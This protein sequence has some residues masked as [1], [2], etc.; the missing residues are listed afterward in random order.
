[1]A[2]LLKTQQDSRFQGAEK[3]TTWLFSFIKNLFQVP[4]PR[5]VKKSLES[6]FFFVYRKISFDRN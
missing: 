6:L 5:L 3:P 4:L 2:N 1:M